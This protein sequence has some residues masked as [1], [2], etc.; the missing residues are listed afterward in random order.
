MSPLRSIFSGPLA[1]GQGRRSSLSELSAWLERQN[2]LVLAVAAAV[3]HALLYGA[4]NRIHLAEP[5]EL[6]MTWVDRAV[7]FL[8]LTLWIYLSAYLLVF[9]AFAL[10]RR[11]GSSAR[12]IFAFFTV[13]GLATLVHWMW[14][15]VYPRAE[16]PVPPDAS[17][18]MHWMMARFRELDSP[19]SCLPS[20]HVA[21]AFLSAFAV[22]GE[23]DRHAP[24]LLVWAALIWAS[25]LTTKQHY[26]VDG[27]AGLLLAVGV[28]A[29]FYARPSAVKR[30]TRA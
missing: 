16:F 12:F 7:P 11:P 5:V 9:I 4:P 18:F 14:P 20:L 15:T 29:L 6:P 10:C 19:A 22:L 27:L 2:K 17:P 1:L 28:W 24:A 26:M 21:A 3:A 8:P 23:R 25:T 30:L 13:V